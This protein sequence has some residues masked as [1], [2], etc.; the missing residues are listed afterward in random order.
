MNNFK[1]NFELIIRMVSEATV[2]KERSFNAL[3]VEDDY[4]RY[5]LTADWCKIDNKPTLYI[6]YDNVHGDR[7]IYYEVSEISRTEI[8][9]LLDVWQEIE[10]R[11]GE[12][13]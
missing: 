12:E 6:T 10:D 4:E 11:V 13:D 8:V 1:E 5:I 9:R 7:Y 3:C 2:L